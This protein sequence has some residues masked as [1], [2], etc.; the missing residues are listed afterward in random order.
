MVDLKQLKSDIESWKFHPAG[1][2]KHTVKLMKLA[3]EEIIS[4][5]SIV[6]KLPENKFRGK[7]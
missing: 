1:S 3:M 5:R 4:L 7:Q 2:I 6:S